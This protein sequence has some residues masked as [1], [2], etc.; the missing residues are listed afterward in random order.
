[1]KV[2]SQP[3]VL[4]NYFDAGGSV[5]SEYVVKT[6][7]RGKQV[8]HSTAVSSWEQPFLRIHLNRPA[9]GVTPPFRAVNRGRIEE[10]PE[11]EHYSYEPND[12]SVGDVD[13]DG[14]YE[15]IVKWNPTNARDNSFRG[16]TGEVYLDCYKLDGRQL[17]RIGLG[18]NI[19]AGAHYTQFMV[20]DLDG[21]GRSEVAC[22]TAPGTVDG[23]GNMYFSTEMTLLP[24][25]VRR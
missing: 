16:Y 7:C 17:W 5:T 8:E 1:M 9:D 2:N 6:L 22:K 21:D 18:K 20:Y 15:I 4:T 10:R 24:I 12:C 3:I 11:G 14:E 25:T 19:R 23:T 13:G